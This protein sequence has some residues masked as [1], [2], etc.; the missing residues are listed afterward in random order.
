MYSYI[1]PIEYSY[2]VGYNYSYTAYYSYPTGYTAL[3]GNYGEEDDKFE[4]SKQFIAFTYGYVNPEYKYLEYEVDFQYQTD[5]ELDDQ[6]QGDQ[7]Q[8]ESGYEDEQVSQENLESEQ[9]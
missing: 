5:Q 8:G 6:E 3:W 2:S 7:Q 9:T 1:L 4:P